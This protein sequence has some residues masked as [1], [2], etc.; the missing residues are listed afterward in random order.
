M[1]LTFEP[2]LADLAQRTTVG[3]CPDHRLAMFRWT[4][5]PAAEAAVST[6]W[7]ESIRH[8]AY[9]D[10]TG[11]IGSAQLWWVSPDMQQ[12]LAAAADSVPDFELRSTDAPD[13]FGAVFFSS[14]LRG[15]ES[16]SEDRGERSLYLNAMSWSVTDVKGTDI[17]QMLI[18]SWVNVLVQGVRRWVC[19]GVAN[20][21]A[22]T[23]LRDVEDRGDDQRASVIEDRSRIAALWL[24]ASQTL[25]AKETEPIPRPA[26]KRQLREGLEIPTLRVIRLRHRRSAGS[27]QEESVP[28]DWSHRWLV[29]GHWRNQ[30]LP[31]EN[32]H[33]PTW[34][35]PYVKG[36][37]DKPLVL[38]DTVKALVQ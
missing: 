29:S 30:W 11:H 4:R 33:R 34:I 5:T 17:S 16:R 12:V 36:P 7:R 1:S 15:V 18:Y 21:T 14:P 8:D 23:R 37:E 10:L 13:R 24:L 6:W 25:A 32:R 35:A 28:Q 27:E 19:I 2:T 20:W 3:E 31:S 22:G 26:A 9:L 38:K